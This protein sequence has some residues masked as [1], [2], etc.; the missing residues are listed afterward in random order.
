M[1]LQ[2]PSPSGGRPPDD[3]PVRMTF[4]HLW[5]GEVSISRQHVLEYA[6]S[7]AQGSP[8]DRWDAWNWGERAGLSGVASA[9]PVLVLALFVVGLAASGGRVVRQDPRSD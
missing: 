8:S 3:D 5:R 2:I 4:A 6:P 9:I 1:Q 7:P